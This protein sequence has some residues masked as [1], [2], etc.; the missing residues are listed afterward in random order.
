MLNSE[1]LE[2][3]GIGKSRAAALLKHFKTVNAIKNATVEELCAA[4]SMTRLAAE[5]V[6]NYYHKAE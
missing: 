5:K 3:E 4:P 6:Y 2:I 1:L